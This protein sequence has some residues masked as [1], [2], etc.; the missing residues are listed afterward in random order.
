MA[1][2]FAHEVANPLTAL[3]S[4]LQFVQNALERKEF[5]SP[6]RAVVHGALQEI[7][8]LGSLLTD[9]RG[10]AHPRIAAL[11]RT[12][13]VKNAQEALACQLEAYRALGITVQ[14]QF[15]DLLPP[16]M[17]DGD[18]IKQVILNLCKNAVEAMPD[19]GCLT[20]NGHLADQM[21]V[22]EISDSGV[23]IPEG[24][25]IF[26]LFKTTKPD[27]SGLGLPLVQQIV[28]AHHGT[29][30]YSTEPGRGTTFRIYL[31][32]ANGGQSPECESTNN[33]EKGERKSMLAQ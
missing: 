32:L 30:E 12:D 11:K 4:A 19:G 13:L 15:N 20:L 23:G 22:L 17:A 6:L 31:P 7:D 33:E 10:I 26:E 18:K 27:G 8:R 25:N 14:L 16:V 28:S 1:S 9:F 29:I 24:V 2:V 21:V 3:S 5:D